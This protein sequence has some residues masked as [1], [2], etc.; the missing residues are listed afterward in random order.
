MRLVQSLET[1][2]YP[3]PGPT[4]PSHQV[5]ADLRPRRVIWEP[6]EL[7]V[8]PRRVLG[9]HRPHHAPD[10]LGRH[11]A[12]QG[13]HPQL[14]TGAVVRYHLLHIGGGH[15]GGLHLPTA[16]VRVDDRHRGDVVAHGVLHRVGVLEV[17]HLLVPVVAVP[18]PQVWTG[19][20]GLLGVQRQL[21]LKDIGSIAGHVGRRLPLVD[22][23][24]GDR[25]GVGRDQVGVAHRADGHHDFQALAIRDVRRLRVAIFERDRHL[26]LAG[27][28]PPAQHTCTRVALAF[29]LLALTYHASG[30]TSGRVALAFDHRGVVG[31]GDPH[32]KLGR[33]SGHQHREPH[34]RREEGLAG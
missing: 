17:G 31:P 21:G 27:K 25:P 6:A 32:L 9:N 12:R 34:R 23:E 13:L 26:C 10:G 22:Q 20:E 2:L 3:V 8:N 18:A 16:V 7:T 4:S 29:S 33:V 30:S 5:A 1:R 24:N 11:R 15:P 19:N 28:S 14:H